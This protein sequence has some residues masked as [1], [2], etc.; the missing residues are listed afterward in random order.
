MGVTALWFFLPPLRRRV[1]E[2]DGYES[3]AARAPNPFPQG[4][5]E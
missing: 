5:G 4:G 2:G 3:N 1:R